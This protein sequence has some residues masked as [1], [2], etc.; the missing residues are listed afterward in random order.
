MTQTVQT[1]ITTCTCM[2][3]CMCYL[4]GSQLGC[5]GCACNVTLYNTNHV[6]VGYYSSDKYTCKRN[7]Y[8]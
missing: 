4:S 5:H 3:M 7:I 2:C 1:T 6:T 8:E